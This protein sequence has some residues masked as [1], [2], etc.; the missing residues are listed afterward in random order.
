MKDQPLPLLPMLPELP[1]AEP[2]P[3]LIEEASPADEGTP[4]YGDFGHPDAEPAPLPLP[5]H[6]AEGGN[7]HDLRNEQTAL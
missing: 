7:V 1:A 6:R 5:D 2:A 3:K 4:K